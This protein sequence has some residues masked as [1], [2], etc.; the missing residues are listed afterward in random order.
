MIPRTGANRLRAP[1]EVYLCAGRRLDTGSCSMRP[2]RRAEIDEAVFRYF[3]QVGMDVEATRRQLADARDAKLAEVRA[4]LTDAEREVATLADAH[5]RI[6]R[7]YLAGNLAPESHDRLAARVADELQGANAQADRLRDQKREVDSWG[8]LQDAETETLRRLSEIRS[9]I[10]GEIT[11]AEGVEAVRAVLSRTFERF[12]VHRGIPDRAHV[13]LI[14]KAWIEP[15]PH[16][17]A[18]EGYTET[19]RPV[20]R[21]EPLAAN[22]YNV[23]LTT[24]SSEPTMVR[25][26]CRSVR[27]STSGWPRQAGLRSTALSLRAGA[28][29]HPWT[30]VTQVGKGWARQYPQTTEKPTAAKSPETAD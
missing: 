1:Y 29:P 22:N 4:L 2:L 10:A 24:W 6:D 7:D 21:R 30:H 20:L 27:P 15:V 9:A 14:G 17:H 11:D 18:I 26:R 25:Q 13:E 16:E 5:D 28:M 19:L 12:I 8:E 23:G 3:L